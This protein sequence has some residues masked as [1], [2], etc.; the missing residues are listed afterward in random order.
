MYLQEISITSSV[1][2]SPSA[3]Q[4]MRAPAALVSSHTHTQRDFCHSIQLSSRQRS[5]LENITVL[6]TLQMEW[7]EKAAF[8]GYHLMTS[9]SYDIT[10]RD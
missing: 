1:A 8:Y 9:S 2:A 6:L 5:R 3:S 10:G 4:S 7:Q